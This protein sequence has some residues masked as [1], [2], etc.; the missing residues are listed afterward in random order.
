MQ[1]RQLRRSLKMSSVATNYAAHKAF[2]IW[3]VVEDV[4][5]DDMQV[6]L[7]WLIDV[8]HRLGVMEPMLGAELA[9]YVYLTRS[10]LDI[11]DPANYDKLSVRLADRRY[12]AVP[13]G[14][15]DIHTGHVLTEVPRFFEKTVY[16]LGALF[17]MK[18]KEL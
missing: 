5:L 6:G 1:L 16:D 8:L 15:Y 7:L 3:P 17:L 14:M 9:R 18:S 12:V 2:E 13:E 4:E 11:R 10:H